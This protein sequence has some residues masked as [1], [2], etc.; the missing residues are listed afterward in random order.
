M[1]VCIINKHHFQLIDNRFSRHH[2][3][4]YFSSR[5]KEG[6]I[7]NIFKIA[8]W[9][10]INKTAEVHKTNIL[11]LYNNSKL[12][13]LEECG[14]VNKPKITIFHQQ[15][16][17]GCS[18]GDYF[19]SSG[20][21]CHAWYKVAQM[22]KR[23]LTKRQPSQSAR[24][25]LSNAIKY[26]QM[27]FDWSKLNYNLSMILM[28][29][30][31][32]ANLFQVKVANKINPP[33]GANSITALRRSYLFA[34]DALCSWFISNGQN[35]P[36]RCRNH[37]KGGWKRAE[38]GPAT[39]AVLG[40]RYA[41][42]IAH[43]ISA[44]REV[45][46]PTWGRLNA[47]LLCYSSHVKYSNDLRRERQLKCSAHLARIELFWVHLKRCIQ[48]LIATQINLSFYYQI[49]QYLWISANE[50]C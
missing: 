25:I 7:S 41:Q 2:F 16:N 21:E 15:A 22:A 43:L 50:S 10:Q 28:I 36:G 26:T 19:F 9:L 37:S 42:S 18:K 8:R 34:L 49:I 33:L 1:P 38:E 46:A 30:V 44:V 32:V 23:L 20:Q 35:R 6:Q 48:L 17:Q 27:P 5:V 11:L 40:V 31:S 14:K 12:P 13:L 47:L 39:C 3:F 4:K 29:T 45:T 24:I